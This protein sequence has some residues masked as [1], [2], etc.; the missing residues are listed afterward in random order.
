[1]AEPNPTES[2]HSRP[3]A[4]VTSLIWIVVIAI[5]LAFAF[6]ASSLCITLLLAAF[7]AILADPVVTRLERLHFP[8][9]LAA[10]SVVL[11]GVLFVALVGYAS[12]GRATSFVD[13]LPEYTGKIRSAMRPLIQRAEKVQESAG[14]LNP[15][16][17]KQK[18][19][20]VRVNETPSW[21][22]YLVR[23]VG[24]A[25]GAIIIAAAVPFLMFF[26][27]IRKDHIY[28][29]LSTTFGRSTDV[30]RFV[31]RVNHMVRGYVVGNV[32]VGGILATATVAV[33][34]GI[35]MDGA[36]T[37]GIASGLLNLIPYLGVILA[38][39]VPLL[40]ATL[41][42]S[43]AGPFVVIAVTAVSLHL[44]AANLLT[45]KVIASRVNVDPVAATVGMLF[46]G[47]LWGAV[48][49]LMA[50]PLTALVKLVTDCH[51]SLIHISNLLAENPRRVP[52]WAQVGRGTFTRAIPFF[53]GRFH[54]E[55]KVNQQN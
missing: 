31:D 35:G 21:P 52:R 44:I 9:T 6:F 27:L 40:A 50:V 15:V 19:P 36:V 49:L 8:R 5:V 13:S 48:G 53:R 28:W 20:V 14:R 26:M 43:S 23:G 38:A 34:L 25:A 1:M 16:A 10:A 42:F 32:L 7:L 11:V 46:W 30:P 39:G 29:W 2:P 18:A 55:K 54:S 37:V 4:R 33:L 51:P 17:P 22:A 24:S 45:P 12:Y 41:Q 47:W 3:L